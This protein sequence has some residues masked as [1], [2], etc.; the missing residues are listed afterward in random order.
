MSL[1]N[2]ERGNVPP[3]MVMDVMNAAARLEAQGRRVIHMEV[4]QPSTPAPRKVLE[5]AQKALGSELLG[6]TLALGTP[7]LRER[8]ARYYREQH[9]LSVDPERIAVTAG[10]LGAF[11]LIFM[12]VFEIGERVALPRPCYPSY[13]NMLGALGIDTV[14]VDTSAERGFQP[15]PEDLDNVEG[16]IDGLIVASPSNPV[17]SM[18]APEEL[19]RLAKYCERHG[20]RLISD[21]IYHGLSYGIPCATAVAYSDSCFS[22]NSFSKYYSM[23]GWRLGWMVMPVNTI[24]QIERLAQ[25]FFICPSAP[26]QYACVAAFDCRDELEQHIEKY[27]RN[28]ALLLSELPKAGFDQLA[29]ADGAFYIYADI[30][31]LSNNSLEFSAR[32][33]EEIGVAATS[34]VDFDPLD[35]HRFLRFSYA[36]STEDMQEAVKRLQSW[37][38]KSF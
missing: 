3:F 21:E 2:A 7:V 9:D 15:T 34:G 31:R 14:L 32:M 11:Q 38:N 10:S 17:G 18:I 28:R 26:A 6:Y 33:L 30:S 20:I 23:T 16:P 8:I 37:G 36:R 19:S 12:A 29:P 35:G 27:A 5:A 1:H 22:V 24:R 25:N 13:R 4:G